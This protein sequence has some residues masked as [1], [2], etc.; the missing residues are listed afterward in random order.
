MFRHDLG[1]G[2]ELRILLPLHAD[3]FLAFVQANRDHLGAWLDWPTYIQ[4]EDD[5]GRF[6]RDG[7]DELVSYGLP[8]VGIWQE[9]EMAG[10]IS[11]FGTSTRLRATEI[12]YW[13]GAKAQG[14]G[15]MTRSLT[16]LLGYAFTEVGINRVVISVEVGNDRSRAI[17]ERLGFTLEGIKRDGW[18]HGEQLVDL[19]VYS[20]LAREWAPG[21]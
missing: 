9:G 1:G 20:M 12:G 15:L 5:A 7:F 3:E 10:G 2:L 13:L 8:T 11:F 16:A 18:R 4:S 6:I 21:V 14:R 19:A 17:P